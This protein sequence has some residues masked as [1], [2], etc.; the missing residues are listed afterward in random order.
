[1]CKNYLDNRLIHKSTNYLRLRPFYSLWFDRLRISN[2][3]LHMLSIHPPVVP[4]AVEGNDIRP[5]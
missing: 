5:I 2:K 3:Q 4:A 1:M